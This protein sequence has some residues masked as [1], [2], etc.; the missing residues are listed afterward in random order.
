M[1]TVVGFEQLRLLQRADKRQ[2]AKRERRGKVAHRERVE[3]ANVAR[4]HDALCVVVIG[5]NRALGEE[6]LLPLGQM[7]YVERRNRHPDHRGGVRCERVVDGERQIGV[8]CGDVTLVE[9]IPETA[10]DDEERRCAPGAPLKVL[11]VAPVERVTDAV[12]GDKREAN[13]TMML[14]GQLQHDIIEHALAMLVDLI[15][16]AAKAIERGEIE[17]KAR[18]NRFKD[19]DKGA[20]CN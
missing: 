13:E 11:Q 3:P 2:T 1:N 10:I 18:S 7:V 4:A 15:E 14:I 5:T 19:I 16:A 9:E 6:W 12:L 17:H 8:V 20:T